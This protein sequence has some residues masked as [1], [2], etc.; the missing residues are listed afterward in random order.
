MQRKITYWL[1]ILFALYLIA[2][3]STGSGEVANSFFDWLGSAFDHGLDFLN[4]TIGDSE[5]TV[6]V[7][8]GP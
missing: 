1:L 7:T 4:A 6:V 2:Q 3:D 8:P 5:P